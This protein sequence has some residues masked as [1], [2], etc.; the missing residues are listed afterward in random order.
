RARLGGWGPPAAAVPPHLRPRLRLRRAGDARL[1]GGAGGAAAPPQARRPAAARRPADRGPGAGDRPPVRAGG[2]AAGVRD[3][4]VK[5]FTRGRGPALPA[6]VCAS[7]GEPG[8]GPTLRPRY[9]AGRAAP[10]P[11][12]PSRRH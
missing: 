4:D 8:V 7:R 12:L 3:R 1:A 10:P 9:A 6:R 2:L 5:R 11:T